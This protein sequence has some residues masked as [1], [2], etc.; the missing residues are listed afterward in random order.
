[1]TTRPKIWRSEQQTV[2]TM[3]SESRLLWLLFTTDCCPPQVH[4]PFVKG[5]R[6]PRY[7]CMREP[8]SF[9]STYT[10]GLV[11][12]YMLLVTDIHI[13]LITQTT[14]MHTITYHY[15]HP[16]TLP[17]TDDE[18]WDWPKCA[19]HSGQLYVACDSMYHAMWPSWEAKQTAFN[20]HWWINQ[21]SI[22]STKSS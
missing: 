18:A 5:W 4:S 13:L 1:M 17:R 2:L 10:L 21:F 7:E 19:P 8:I 3:S 22:A 6:S 20:M 9:P 11:G 14:W 12:W 16:H 15:M